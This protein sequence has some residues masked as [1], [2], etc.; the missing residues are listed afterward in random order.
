MAFPHWASVPSSE[1]W[2]R[3]GV[4]TTGSHSS[5]DTGCCSARFI[6]SMSPPHRWG[7]E[8]G[9]REGDHSS[10]NHKGDTASNFSPAAS[11]SEQSWKKETKN[12][13]KVG[14]MSSLTGVRCRMTHINLDI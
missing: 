3:L 4:M 12:R 10:T 2:E 14:S 9:G 1:K 6:F 8:S 11:R 5:S 7:G 13:H